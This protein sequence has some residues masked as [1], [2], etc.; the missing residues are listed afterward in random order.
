MLQYQAEIRNKRLKRK[1]ESSSRLHAGGTVDTDDLSIDPVTILRGEEAD[2]AGNVDGLTDTVVGRPCAGVLIDLVVAEL[3]TTGNVF[4]ADSVVHV[5]LDATGGNAVDCN[6][7]L[8]S[9]YCSSVKCSLVVAL[10]DL[11]IAI[12]LVKVSMA[13]LEPE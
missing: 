1:V 9:I 5:S 8:T 2:N 11:P 13:P 10:K 4:A 6:L 7:L 12:H 3:V